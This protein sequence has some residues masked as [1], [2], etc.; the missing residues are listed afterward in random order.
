MKEYFDDAL[1]YMYEHVCSKLGPLAFV[2]A[3]FQLL[4]KLT[5][6]KALTEVVDA[7]KADVDAPISA[8]KVVAGSNAGRC[9]FLNQ[10]KRMYYQ[11]FQGQIKSQLKHLEFHDFEEDEVAQVDVLMAKEA[12]SLRDYGYSSSSKT[13]FQIRFL[14]DSFPF[15]A[16]GPLAEYFCQKDA[17]CKTIGINFGAISPH[18]WESLVIQ[19]GQMED[20]RETCQIPLSFFEKTINCRR[21]VRQLFDG[22]S[23]L[24]LVE[25]KSII[26]NNYQALVA[27]DERFGIEYEYLMNIVGPKLTKLLDAQVFAT[28]PDGKAVKTYAQVF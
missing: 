9:V 10:L 25:M 28:L 11:L 22:R 3:N 17:V 19:P 18:P 5:C 7:L 1:R 21:A 4:A 24:S 20:V 6:G 27:L 12:A 13:T 8:L 15:E 26:S 14:E 16:H 2:V 23:G